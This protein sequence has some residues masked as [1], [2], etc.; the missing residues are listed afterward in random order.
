[1][2]V[3]IAGAS[4]GFGQ[5]L[6]ARLRERGYQVYGTSR[7]PGSAAG[8]E[9][10]LQLDVRDEASVAACVARAREE[11]G[12]I[13]VLVNCAGYVHEGPFEE[14]TSE[15]LKAIFETNFFGAVRLANAVLPDMRA[16]GSGRIVNVG[17]MAGVI[18]LPFLG[19]YCASKS[20]LDSY[21]ESLFH[22]LRPLGVA[23]HVVE[24]SYYSTGI[25]SRK[26]RTTATI[27][28]YDAQRERMY[29]TIARDE[30]QRSG[31][32]GPVVDLLT[33]IVEGRV[34]RFRHVLG[35]DSVT[36]HL[37]GY[38]PEW[39]WTFGMRRATGLD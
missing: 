19:A 32:P 16:R 11:A 34:S 25:A 24:P 9:P 20:A 29:R 21:S 27:V 7:R 10:L 28:D 1:M 8:A 38:L 39:A 13:D 12:R 14:L 5:L 4:S 31:P 23:V 18:P 33:R 35:P 36:W 2:V 6:A 30:E 3:L 15:E 17:S 37:R 22:E 26:L